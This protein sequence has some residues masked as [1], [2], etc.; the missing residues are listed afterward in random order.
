MGRT[1]GAAG[2]QGLLPA[3]QTLRRT[4]D[5]RGLQRLCPGHFGQDGGQALGQH[6]LAGARRP[7]HQNMVSA[8]GGDLQRPLDV[9]LSLHVGK[10]GLGLL[11]P[12]PAPR[13]GPAPAAPGR[14]GDPAVGPPSPPGRP[15]F[16]PPAWPPGRCPPG[17]TAFQ[18]PSPGPPAPWAA[19]PS[20]PA[21]ARS[22]RSPPQSRSRTDLAS[23]SPEA[24]RIPSRMGRSYTVPSFFRSA[25]E[26]FTGD[27]GHREAEPGV[28]DGGAH[29]LLGLLDGGVRQSHDLKGGQASR[30]IALHPARRSRQCR[31]GRGNQW[32]RPWDASF[33]SSDMG[34][35][36][37][38][39]IE[40]FP[41]GE[42]VCEAD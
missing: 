14:S 11:C 8:C 41:L 38:Q 34:F 40:G 32:K 26:R 24:F 18:C 21:P 29:P 35:G 4:P 23:S 19:F 3:G 27:P 16:R 17:R 25:G 7:H 22:G 6:A 39:T 1:E 13:P 12:P 33:L 15:A 5:L 28:A 30:Q 36:M 37:V 20:R 9:G 10:I 2:E 42:A 31:A